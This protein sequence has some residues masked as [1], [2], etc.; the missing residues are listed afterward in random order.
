MK[1]NLKFEISQTKLTYKKDSTQNITS[2]INKTLK[3][4]IINHLPNSLS[5]FH[6]SI[7]YTMFVID[8]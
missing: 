2:F 3:K 1:A 7:N 8:V 6:I 4:K 5:K